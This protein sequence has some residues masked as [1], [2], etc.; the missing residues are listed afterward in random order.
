M[1][2]KSSYQ[3]IMIG[4]TVSAFMAAAPL[5]YASSDAHGGGHGTEQTKTKTP[6]EVMKM[7]ISGNDEFKSHHDSGSFDAYQT[8]QV[9]NITLI[10]CSDSRVQTNLFGIDPHNNLFVVRNIGNQIKNAEGSVDYGVRHLPT[11][12]LMIVGHSGCGAVKAAMGDYSQETK[13]IK[14]E[15][16]PLAEPLK[17]DDGEGAPETRWA[18]NVERNVDYQVSYAKKLY[19]DKVNAG[20]LVIVGGVYDFNNLYGKGRGTLVITNINGTTEPNAIM[21][22]PTLK[23]LSGAQVVNHVGSLAP[24]TSF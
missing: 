12:V 13:G 19:V 20:E 7:V 5:A 24:D 1:G 6:S 22:S 3:K 15:L 21:N 16:A 18:K 23:D 4:L 2:K 10:S 8:K 9:P 11:S 14:E 17:A